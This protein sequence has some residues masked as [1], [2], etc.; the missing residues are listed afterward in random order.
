[1]LQLNKQTKYDLAKI[2]REYRRRETKRKIAKGVIVA[3]LVLW[4]VFSIIPLYWMF[5]MSFRDLTNAAYIE[6]TWWIKNPTLINFKRFFTETKALRWLLNS[7]IVSGAVTISNVVFASAAG[8]AFAKLKIPGKNKIFWAILA[9]MMIPSQVTLI[10]MYI[11]IVNKFGLGDTYGA[12]IIPPLCTINNVFLMKQYMSTLPT[13][14]IHAARIDGCS[15]FGV[16]RKVI[17]PIAKPGIAVLAIFT[18]VAM[19]NDFFWPF[20][21]TQSSSMRTIQVGLASFSTMLNTDWGLTMAG[22]VV[23]ALPMFVLFF[24]LQKYF[25]K[26]ITIGAV[27]G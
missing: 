12:I 5:M 1:M 20:L 13:S 23:A 24:S 4:A 6:P 14:L 27:K 10:P 18:F 8:Y 25:L 3:I 22:S 11:M 17:L 26:G 16:Y 21:I 19:W 7:L 9:G 15:E 2:E